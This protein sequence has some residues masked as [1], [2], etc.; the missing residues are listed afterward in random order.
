MLNPLNDNKINQ[1]YLYKMY[2]PLTRWSIF[3][4]RFHVFDIFPHVSSCRLCLQQTNNT[5]MKN[6]FSCSTTST[7]TPFRHLQS[8]SSI[9][10]FAS[11]ESHRTTKLMKVGWDWSRNIRLGSSSVQE[12]VQS[13]PISW[14]GYYT[15]LF[16]FAI[17]VFFLIDGITKIAPKTLTSIREW[18]IVTER[19]FSLNE[20]TIQTLAQT[21]ELGVHNISQK[22][23]LIVSKLLNIVRLCFIAHIMSIICEP[24]CGWLITFKLNA[25]H[26]ILLAESTTYLGI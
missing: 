2:A 16:C 10:A 5:P 15:F 12:T 14:R 1:Q 7:K 4:W 26:C 21:V 9:F 23:A 20:K 24:A 18:R 19:E 11:A 25:Y 22:D 13:K 8:L 6:V 3:F 17:P